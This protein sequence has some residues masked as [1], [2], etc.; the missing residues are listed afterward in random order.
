[1]PGGARNLWDCATWN[2][3]RR[4]SSAND[5]LTWVWRC[6]LR[7]RVGHC[8]GQV[9]GGWCSLRHGPVLCRQAAAR[10]KPDRTLWVPTILA[11]SIKVGAVRDALDFGDYL[12]LARAA[13]FGHAG[14][15]DSVPSK[16]SSQAAQLRRR[17]R[18]LL[19]GIVTC[20][21]RSGAT[22]YGEW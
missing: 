11:S 22:L 5:P 2:F 3:W 6:M 13:D 17:C 8:T 18:A 20:E 9:S 7:L 12:Q 16:G 19:S 15:D 14:Y 4:V 10:W 1:M 21:L